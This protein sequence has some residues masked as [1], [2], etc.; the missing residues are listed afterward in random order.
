MGNDEF[1]IL[2]LDGPREDTLLWWKPN[3]AGY[4]SDVDKAGR[5]ART[6][7]EADP[8]YYNNGEKT[9][10]ILASEAVKHA[11]RVVPST[12]FLAGPLG[13]ICR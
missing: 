3:N 13:E 6:V 4:T 7:V 8:R 9:K 12:A 11:V 1:L 5:Y 10:A 2:C